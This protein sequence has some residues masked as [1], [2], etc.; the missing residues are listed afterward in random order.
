MDVVSIVIG[1]ASLALAIWS[2][3]LSKKGIKKSDE[4]AKKQIQSQAF[5]DFSSRYLEISKN[6]QNATVKKWYQQ[7][8]LDL[9]RDEFVSNKQGNLPKEVWDMFVERMRLTVKQDTSFLTIW[10]NYAQTFNQDFVTFFD[11]EVFRKIGLI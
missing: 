11:N 5:S 9:C 7:R 6:L 1:G 10:K 2:L 3:V 4:N 8:Y